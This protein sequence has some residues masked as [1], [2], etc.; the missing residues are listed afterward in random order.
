MSGHALPSVNPF[1]KPAA[2]HPPGSRFPVALLLHKSPE[3]SVPTGSKVVTPRGVLFLINLG[4]TPRSSGLQLPQQE[5]KKKKSS[6]SA[7]GGGKEAGGWEL[8]AEGG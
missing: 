7:A 6:C 2:P 1:C 4:L 5:V 8:P 3:C